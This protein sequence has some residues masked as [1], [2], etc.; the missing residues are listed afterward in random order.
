MA[1]LFEEVPGSSPGRE[2]LLSEFS[3]RIEGSG[4]AC[5]PESRVVVRNAH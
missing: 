2:F 1:D 3:G 5:Y 4:V